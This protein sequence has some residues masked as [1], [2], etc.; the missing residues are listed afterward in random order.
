MEGIEALIAGALLDRGNRNLENYFSKNKGI[1]RTH[2]GKLLTQ[3]FDFIEDFDPLD[4]A[5]NEALTDGGI[6]CACGK[7]FSKSANC[8]STYRGHVLFDCTLFG[9]L[10]PAIMNLESSSNL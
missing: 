2:D 1:K 8:I 9:K 6:L 4:L 7:H 3:Q 5:I 10:R